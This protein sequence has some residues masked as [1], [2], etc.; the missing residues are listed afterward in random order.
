MN[1]YELLELREEAGFWEQLLDLEA[2]RQRVAEGLGAYSST[3]RSSIQIQG[4]WG[5]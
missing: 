1:M 2:P 3:P 4:L 5:C